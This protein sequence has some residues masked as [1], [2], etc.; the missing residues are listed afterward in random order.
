MVLGVLILKHFRV[1]CNSLVSVQFLGSDMYLIMIHS[2]GV[3]LADD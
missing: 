3:Y 1:I 2:T